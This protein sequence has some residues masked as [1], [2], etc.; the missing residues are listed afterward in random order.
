[1]TIEQL[2]TKIK[3]AAKAYYEGFP[4]ISDKEFDGLI[5]YL[6][7]C[8]PDSEILTSTGWGYNPNESIGEK[9]NHLYGKITGIDKKPTVIENIPKDFYNSKLIESAK[10][11]GCSIVCYFING[12]LTNAI[13]RGNGE[14][15]INRI[16]KISYILKKELIIPDE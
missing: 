16:D 9:L 11:D 12:K 5:T 13:T 3:N 8:K 1:M 4:I 14:V 10:L 2:E 15:G 7:A 6:R